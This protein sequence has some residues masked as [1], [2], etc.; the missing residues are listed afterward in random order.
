MTLSA[1]VSH[2]LFVQCFSVGDWWFLPKLFSYQSSKTFAQV[3]QIHSKL[4]ALE[5]WCCH[6][7]TDNRV[8]VFFLTLFK[9]NTPFAPSSISN[10][11][12]ISGVAV[13]FILGPSL[14]PEPNATST[15]LVR[16]MGLINDMAE[17][18]NYNGSLR[19]LFCEAG[20]D[21]LLT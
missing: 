11:N 4:K 16:A 10:I 17:G 9:L 1:N 20:N 7:T 12:H 6:A 13:P 2:N 15:S 19:F 5:P 21:L 8:C 18:Y 14:L 3:F